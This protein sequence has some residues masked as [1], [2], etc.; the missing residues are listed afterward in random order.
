M[1]VAG[2]AW[3]VFWFAIGRNMHD[4]DFAAS[5]PA[6]GSDWSYYAPAYPFILFA[7]WAVL[8]ITFS[9]IPGIV[10]GVGM[11]QFKPCAR[12][13]GMAVSIANIVLLFPLHLLLGIYGL[14]I[15]TK[16]EARELFARESS[17]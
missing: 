5:Y 2:A 13:V 16:H 12:K 11:L 9:A 1:A 17:G 7:R 15:L 10:A 3:C 4:F 8:A 6:H 14:V